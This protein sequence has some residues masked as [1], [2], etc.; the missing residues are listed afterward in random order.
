MSHK[1][2]PKKT[3]K[4]GKNKLLQEVQHSNDKNFRSDEVEQKSRGSN[5][6]R[7]PENFPEMND[8]NFQNEKTV[9]SPE[10]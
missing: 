4:R 7:I 3:E 10:K 6:Q 2:E 5:Y 9:D 1:V 8:M